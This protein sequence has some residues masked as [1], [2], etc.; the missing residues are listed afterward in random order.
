LN[1]ILAEALS[2]RYH[3]EVMENKEEWEEFSPLYVI[4]ALYPNA[5]ED[6]EFLKLLLNEVKRWLTNLKQRKYR[7][8][9]YT[10]VI[11]KKLSDELGI[12]L[13]PKRGRPRGT[14]TE[15]RIYSKVF[16][17]YAGVY[18]TTP[19]ESKAKLLAVLNEG[20]QRA[21]EELQR[22]EKET[23]EK[24]RQEIKREGVEEVIRKY[25]TGKRWEKGSERK[26]Y[27][28]PL[29]W[30]V[31]HKNHRGIAKFIT[32]YAT[33]KERAHLSELWS[34]IYELELD[35]ARKA[36]FRKRGRR[37]KG[38]AVAREILIYVLSDRVEKP[39]AFLEALKAQLEYVLFK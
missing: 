21:N 3:I 35:R 18:G 5:G 12:N 4:E 20:Y 34:R 25:L 9:P 2:H 29:D 15:A 16:E 8:I 17:Y 22:L 10:P 6:R 14:F 13:P 1:A 11:R 7:N 33:Q 23:L 19:V 28:T 24:V 38:E 30:A 26:S 39:Y 36:Y 37:R 32:Y 27:K 31:D